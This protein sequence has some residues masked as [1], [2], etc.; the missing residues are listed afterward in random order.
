MH[1]R[2]GAAPAPL[3]L[4]NRTDPQ[5]AAAAVRGAAGDREAARVRDAARRIVERHSFC[6][7]ATA[8]RRGHAHVVGVEYA[9]VG[10]LLYVHTFDDSRKARNI[11]EN[12]RVG[13]CI[14]VRRIPFAPPFC[15]QFQ[16]AAEL[17]EVDHP[18][19]EAL[20][21]SG[22][23]KKITAFGAL[24]APRACFIRITPGRTISTYGIGVSLITLL[25]D[26]LRAS[27]TVALS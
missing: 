7:L 18:E 3:P 23:L 21:P 26:P 10:Q 1:D 27:R 25:R 2:L 9:L 5:L 14:P 19:I 4:S 24:T 12:P 20:L 22:C 17:L 11:R 8:S 15:V 16:A 6:T 13:V